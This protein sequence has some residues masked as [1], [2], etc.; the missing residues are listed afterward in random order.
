[1]PTEKLIGGIRGKL[2]FGLDT[3]VTDETYRSVDIFKNEVGYRGQNHIDQKDSL[4]A[5]LGVLLIVE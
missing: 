4:Q 5:D 2:D 1:M 3:F